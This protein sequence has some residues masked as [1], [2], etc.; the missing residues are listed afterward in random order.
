MK[1][2]LSKAWGYL[3]TAVVAVPALAALVMWG[4]AWRRRAKAAE[5]S[6]AAAW[7]AA[8]AAERR[9]QTEQRVRKAQTDAIQ[10]LRFKVQGLEAGIEVRE[11]QI[12]EL[13]TTAEQVNAAFTPRGNADE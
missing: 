8:N 11:S 9:R 1:A 2:W 4:Q 10:A 13:R 3:V 6:R 5:A 7:E 12:R